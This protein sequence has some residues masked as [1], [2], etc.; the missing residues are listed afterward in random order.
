MLLL[1]A[2]AGF[3]IAAFA[4]VEAMGYVAL[5]ALI[6]IPY[7][8]GSGICLSA[9]SIGRIRWLLLLAV[10]A[11]LIAAGAW[12]ARVM[13]MNEFRQAPGE[14]LLATIAIPL[15]MFHAWSAIA[16]IFWRRRLR[17]RL[18]R[19]LSVA[20][21]GVTGAMAIYLTVFLLSTQYGEQRSRYE[22]KQRVYRAFGAMPL[23]V[24]LV[25]GT[26]LASLREAGRLGPVPEDWQDAIE[27][28][29]PRCGDVTTVRT[30]GDTCPTCGLDIRIIPV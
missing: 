4:D 14:R 23:Y 7:V 2:G 27:L 24:L 29:C 26:S 21:I 10:F 15:T 3:L 20:L 18:A 11:G 28:A 19:G 8:A 1:I 9:A 13:I 6:A 25:I 5:T 12:S 30:Y 16:S 22:A 17:A